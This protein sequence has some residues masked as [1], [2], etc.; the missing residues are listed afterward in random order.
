MTPL[1]HNAADV[2]ERAGHPPTDEIMRLADPAEILRRADPDLS[3]QKI[4]RELRDVSNAN[5]RAGHPDEIPLQAANGSGREDDGNGG[6]DDGGGGDSAGGGGGNDDVLPSATDAPSVT[7]LPSITDASSLTKMWTTAVAGMHR[8]LTEVSKWEAMKTA[9]GSSGTVTLS[10]SFG[11]GTYTLT[12]AL[13]L[14][15]IDFSDI[16]NSKALDAKEKG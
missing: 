14:G 3:H 10:N 9:C 11:M 5:E 15:G 2:T 6:G 8:R 16:G 4:G 13:Q 7:V 12:P 1:Y